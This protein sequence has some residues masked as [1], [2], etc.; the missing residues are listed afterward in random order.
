MGVNANGEEETLPYVDYVEYILHV[1]FDQPIRSKLEPI[2]FKDQL[3]SY[4]GASSGQQ[5]LIQTPLL[6]QQR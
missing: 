3:L 2:L 4:V 5:F 6:Q 1:T